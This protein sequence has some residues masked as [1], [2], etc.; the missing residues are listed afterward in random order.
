MAVARRVWQ[1]ARQ[2]RPSREAV[3]VGA[4]L[5][6]LGAGSGVL[7]AVGRGGV[8]PRGRALDIATPETAATVTR[9]VRRVLAH[10]VVSDGATTVEVR[11][12]YLSITETVRTV[13]GK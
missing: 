4:G 9:T 5:A 6:V 7:R 13:T 10:R 11:E 2:V 12:A 1:L 3:A 8:L